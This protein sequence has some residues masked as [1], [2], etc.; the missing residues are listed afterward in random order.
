[1]HS[2][3]GTLNGNTASIVLPKNKVKLAP[4][5]SQVHMQS[6]VIRLET[7]PNGVRKLGNPED[8]KITK[9]PELEEYSRKNIFNGEWI[10]RLIDAFL[11]FFIDLRPKWEAGD[12][13]YLFNEKEY[14]TIK[15]IGSRQH[16]FVVVIEYV[17]E[18]CMNEYSHFILQYYILWWQDNPV[19]DK[20]I[21]SDDLP[22]LIKQGF[23]RRLT[24]TEL[25]ET[26]SKV[27]DGSVGRIF[28]K[29]HQWGSERIRSATYQ[30]PSIFRFENSSQ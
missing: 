5:T 6:V 9:Y 13:I 14:A 1:M 17:S 22:F 24:I 3:H 7:K 4:S 10:L 2:I 18:V 12:R 23:G 19:G 26:A 29:L 28:T 21:S 16:I 25:N 11:N 15:W 8:S 30:R 27:P 20:V